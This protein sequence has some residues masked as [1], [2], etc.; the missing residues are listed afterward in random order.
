MFAKSRARALVVAAATAGVIGIAAPMAS[1]GGYPSSPSN[2]AAGLI[3]VPVQVCGNDILGGVV[4]T[5]VQVLPI[6]VLG[7]GGA[8]STGP[9]LPYSKASC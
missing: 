7:T 1:A 2:G 9:A 8:A 3:A 6:G 5:L 4:E